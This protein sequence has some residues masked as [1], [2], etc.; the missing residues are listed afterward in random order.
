MLWEMHGWTEETITN[1]PDQIIPFGQRLIVG[2]EAELE[3]H[4]FM[5]L[6]QLQSEGVGGVGGGGGGGGDLANGDSTDEKKDAGVITPDA[7]SEGYGPVADGNVALE[8]KNPTDTFEYKPIAI[9]ITWEPVDLMGNTSNV[10]TQKGQRIE[11][12]RIASCPMFGDA[13]LPPNPTEGGTAQMYA[14]LATSTKRTK[15]E[16]DYRLLATQPSQYVRGVTVSMDKSEQP[17]WV[18]AD[19]RLFGPFVRIR[20]MPMADLFTKKQVAMPINT[21]LPVPPSS[22]FQLD[23]WLRILIFFFNTKKSK[24]RG[25]CHF[26]FLIVS[27]IATAKVCPL[28]VNIKK[29]ENWA[30]FN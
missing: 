12:L 26:C 4:K 30:N 25:C 29:N 23:L 16:E 11:E 6:Q 10:I 17:I 8:E 24:V 7:F 9:N 3:G 2:R 22:L 1:T 20:I 5:C 15:Q 19:G 27:K 14:T 21:F 28:F 18:L 13:G